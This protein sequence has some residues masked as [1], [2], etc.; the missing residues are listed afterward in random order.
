MVNAGC[1]YA[2]IVSEQPFVLDF[3][4]LPKMCSDAK[5]YETE[6][7]QKF[8]EEMK[9]FWKDI[10]DYMNEYFEKRNTKYDGVILPTRVPKESDNFIIYMYPEAEMGCFTKEHFDEYHLHQLDTPLFPALI[11]KPYKLP[12]YFEALPG[13]IVYLSLGSLFSA[14]THRLQEIVD[15]LEKIPDYKYIVSEESL[16]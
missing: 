6:K 9:P 15:V 10:C 11:P 1:P 3:D 12:E 4:G 7:I 16:T 14:Y 13:K 2:F 8:D 5:T